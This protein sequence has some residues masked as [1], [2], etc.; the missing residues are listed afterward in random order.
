M[1]AGPLI[2]QW[3][4]QLIF[5]A[6]K[7]VAP[8]T[9]AWP[10]CEDEASLSGLSPTIT[11]WYDQDCLCGTANGLQ[12]AAA[13]STQLTEGLEP[14]AILSVVISGLGLFLL[15]RLGG[16]PVPDRPVGVALYWTWML[17]QLLQYATVALCC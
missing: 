10:P 16:I 8:P 6:P 5:D 4:W 12:M 15:C 14:D 17:V 7:V 2:W 1:E 9:V 11:L 3:I 13:L